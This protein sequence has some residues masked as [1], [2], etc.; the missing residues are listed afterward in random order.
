MHNYLTTRDVAARLGV[1]IATV[2]RWAATGKLPTAT[3]LEGRTGPRLFDPV[4]VD[5]FREGWAA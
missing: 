4:E 2:N 3:K 5:A 1:S